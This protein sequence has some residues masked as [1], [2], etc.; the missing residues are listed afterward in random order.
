MLVARL[1]SKYPQ[2]NLNSYMDVSREGMGAEIDARPST[3]LLIACLAIT[4][5]Y[6]KCWLQ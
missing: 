2:A 4:W 3:R 6:A 1:L 5:Y